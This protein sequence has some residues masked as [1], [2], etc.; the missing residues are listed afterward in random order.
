LP[1]DVLQQFQREVLAATRGLF[2]FC[3]LSHDPHSGL[4][5]VLTLG[6]LGAICG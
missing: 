3:G 4:A 6:F 1:A 5:E 2:S